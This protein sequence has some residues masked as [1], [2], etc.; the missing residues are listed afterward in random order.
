MITRRR[1]LESLSAGLSLDASSAGRQG[2]IAMKGQ[3]A[4][5]LAG[6][7][8]LSLQVLAQLGTGVLEVAA[9][10]KPCEIVRRRA[11]RPREVGL[12]REQPARALQGGGFVLPQLVRDRAPRR[13]DL[14]LPVLQQELQPPYC[15]HDL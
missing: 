10:G 11:G 13:A 3:A 2:L 15:G 14:R 5:S 7:M 6:R 9:R 8:G 12:R 1:K 4:Q